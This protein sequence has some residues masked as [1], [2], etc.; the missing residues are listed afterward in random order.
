M[1]HHYRRFVEHLRL[2]NFSLRTIESYSEAV[3]R[4][5]RFCRDR[6]IHSDSLDSARTYLLYLKVDLDRSPSTVNV[7]YSAVKRYFVDGQVAAWTIEAIPRSR[8]PRRL[9][10]VLSK[11]QVLQLFEATP[12]WRDRMIFMVTY[13]GGLRRNEVRHLRVEDIDS[14]RMR[15]FVHKAKGD[16]ER[17]VMLSQRL[18]GYLRKYWL[19]ERPR[20]FLFPSDKK[21]GEPIVGDTISRAFRRSRDRA[22]LPRRASFHCLR[23]SF[24]CHL[25]EDRVPLPHIKA[26]LG[27]S[28]IKSTMIYLKV[29]DVSSKVTSPLDQ[30]GVANPA[31]AGDL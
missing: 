17:Y 25:L 18:L 3:Q 14:K 27:H 19:I 16:K 20:S 22:R 24:A 29:T 8:R 9:P 26:L 15:I 6:R 7:V 13:A 2:R 21:L 11:E 28:S 30:L 1:E 12:G 23:H 4:Y 5:F 31:L 10:V